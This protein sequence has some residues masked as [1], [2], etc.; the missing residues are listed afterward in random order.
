MDWPLILVYVTEKATDPALF[1]LALVVGTLI[2][3]YGQ[4]L[5]PLLR[6]HSPVAALRAEC[7]VRPLL[8]AVSVSIA[9]LFPFTVG[10][11]SGVAT[12]YVQRHVEA[13]AIFPDAKPD[14]V[15]RVDLDGI[16]VDMGARTKGIFENHTVTAQHV[17]GD[18]VWQEILRCHA[19]KTSIEIDTV[20]YCDLVDSWYLVAHSASEDHKLINLYLTHI[21][22][23]L[24]KMV[25]DSSPRRHQ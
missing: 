11:V 25:N 2:N 6:G 4:I 16:V 14:P 10:L 5:V 18:Q 21:S 22:A 3:L 23:A 15:F 12:R 9:F 24:G 20:I 7:K 17:L 13:H 19:A 8:A 1:L